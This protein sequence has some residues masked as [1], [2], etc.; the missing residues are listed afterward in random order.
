MKN[1]NDSSS[2]G[3]VTQL[4]DG[5]GRLLSTLDELDLRKETFIFFT[6]DNGAEIV[7]FRRSG[8]VAQ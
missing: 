5:F 7:Y 2:N 8:E 1:G 3:N 6:S 4:D